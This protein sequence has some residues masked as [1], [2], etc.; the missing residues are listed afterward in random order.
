MIFVGVELTVFGFVKGNMKKQT[1]IT[2]GLTNPLAPC[3]RA[4]ISDEI[5]LKSYGVTPYAGD[6]T[7]QGVKTH[8]RNICVFRLSQGLEWMLQ[9]T[10]R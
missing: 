3:N 5:A 10:P 2:T 4:A 9:Q 7:P 1:L 8:C 6:N